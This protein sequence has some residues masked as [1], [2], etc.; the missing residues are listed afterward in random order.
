MGEAAHRGLPEGA[1][2]VGV[3]GRACPGQQVQR[4][5]AG[6]CLVYSRQS[7]EATEGENVGCKVSRSWRP[8]MC[9]VSALFL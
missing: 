3:G 7:Q 8:G 1:S 5:E 2:H 4:P 6:V 9:R